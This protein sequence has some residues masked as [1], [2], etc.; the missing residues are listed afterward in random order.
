MPPSNTAAV[1]E[2][3]HPRSWHVQG[4]TAAVFE[5]FSGGQRQFGADLFVET[6]YRRWIVGQLRLGGRE[7]AQTALAD[8]RLSA[9]A[10]VGGAALG[11]HLGQFGRWLAANILVRLQTQLS[12]FRVQGTSSPM[13][14]HADLGAM[15]AA[16]GPSLWLKF[17][18]YVSA[19]LE[20]G[21]GGTLHGVIIRNQGAPVASI[22][23]LAFFSALGLAAQF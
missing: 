3:Q 22:T 21:L 12:Q 5:Q 2:G 17:N 10:L 20:V 18:R 8:G 16:I 4:G 6:R 9:R 15:S 14:Q 1:P 11:V 19:G 13:V 23:G 7:M